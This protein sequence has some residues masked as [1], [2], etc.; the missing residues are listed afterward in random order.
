[1]LIIDQK[2]RFSFKKLRK[3][4]PNWDELTSQFFRDE[5]LISDIPFKSQNNSQLQSKKSFSK[6]SIPNVISSENLK[7]NEYIP[8]SFSNYITTSSKRTNRVTSKRNNRMSNPLQV[9]ITPEKIKAEK[10][11][12]PLSRIKNENEDSSLNRKF[13][14]QSNVD[15]HQTYYSNTNGNL[16]KRGGSRSIQSQKIINSDKYINTNRTYYVSKGSLEYT[17]REE[18]G[19]RQ[20]HKNVIN[21]QSR[22]I[23]QS[24]KNLNQ[25]LS[26]IDRISQNL[27]KITKNSKKPSTNVSSVS[28]VIHMS[29]G[30]RNN[31]LNTSQ[32]YQKGKIK[33]SVKNRQSRPRSMNPTNIFEDNRI[34]SRTSSKPFFRSQISPNQKTQSIRIYRRSYNSH[35]NGSKPTHPLY[36]QVK[37]SDTLESDFQK[38]ITP[39]Q[40]NQ[41]LGAKLMEN[42]QGMF[43]RKEP[44]K[45]NRMSYKEIMKMRETSGLWEDNQKY[46]TRS[47]LESSKR[48]S[49][50]ECIMEVQFTQG[51]SQFSS[52]QQISSRMNTGK[53]R[54][55]RLGSGSSRDVIKRVIYRRPRMSE[56]KPKP[57]KESIN[58]V[59]QNSFKTNNVKIFDSNNDLQ[60]NDF[61]PRRL[62]VMKRCGNNE[63][64][65]ENKDNPVTQK[66]NVDPVIVFKKKE[67]KLVNKISSD[68]KMRNERSSSVFSNL[69]KRKSNDEKENEQNNSR[70]SSYSKRK[71]RFHEKSSEKKSRKS[72]KIKI[73]YNEPI[74]PIKKLKLPPLK[75]KSQNREK[76]TKLK[77]SPGPLTFGKKRKM[78]GLSPLSSR[79]SNKKLRS[80]RVSSIQFKITNSNLDNVSIESQDSVICDIS[81]FKEIDKANNQGEDFETQNPMENSNTV[82]RENNEN[83]MFNDVKTKYTESRIR[84][85]NK[86]NTN[87]T[88]KLKYTKKLE[89]LNM[90]HISSRKSNRMEKKK[91]SSRNELFM[92]DTNGRLV[93]EE[94]F[95]NIQSGS[96]DSDWGRNSKEFRNALETFLKQKHI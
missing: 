30:P 40:N 20:S 13:E 49:A 92:F 78:E 33:T 43:V 56:K 9:E 89:R 66:I 53:Q 85:E 2:K 57:M 1:M 52:R 86:E 22:S 87:H 36:K 83:M 11:I 88:R 21:S 23:H 32:N 25:G 16:T 94:L 51:N 12:D 55:M 64:V 34:N 8:S 31:S 75:R 48:R 60:N 63:V 6:L 74:K 29:Q 61:L 26:E 73:K 81:S 19:S 62:N 76:V 15:S 80:D 71:N 72:S 37:M 45:G 42:I 17:H 96:S 28:R 91:L 50:K 90:D 10:R 79:R 39:S 46:G 82:K 70:V 4:L 68:R 47:N 54:G 35:Q 44:S 77:I 95:G 58:V 3:A 93:R 41:G 18:Y 84:Y 67:V 5:D 14:G 24:S 59:V 38:S 65:K 7:K 27:F 69:K